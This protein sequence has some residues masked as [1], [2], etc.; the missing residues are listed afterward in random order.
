VILLLDHLKLD[1]LANINDGEKL[2]IVSVS[3]FGTHVLG[4]VSISVTFLSEAKGTPSASERSLP[5]VHPLM[6][7]NIAQL[8]EFSEA[9]GAFEYLVVPAGKDISP[10]VFE[11]SNLIASL[12]DTT[13][14]NKL[15]ISFFT[16]SAV[17]LIFLNISILKAFGLCVD[18]REFCSSAD[19]VHLALLHGD[20]TT[21]SFD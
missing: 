21:G 4:F 11:R 1:G 9:D 17:L 7:A 5:R 16:F 6:V 18:S 15:L 10:P 19:T 13:L 2:T 8:S 14:L 12:I 3:Q 20:H